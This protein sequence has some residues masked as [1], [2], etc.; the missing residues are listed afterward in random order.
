MST[1]KYYGRRRRSSPLLPD[2]VDIIIES[3]PFEACSIMDKFLVYASSIIVVGS[4]I[5]FYG[6]IITAFK[7]WRHYR[8]LANEAYAKTASNNNRY[9]TSSGESSQERS[10]KQ[11]PL[12]QEEIQQS[13]HV[14]MRNKLIPCTRQK[15]CWY[16]DSWCYLSWVPPYSQYQCF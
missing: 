8:Q 15:Q 4:P 9:A 14:T 7:R 16:V 13:N 1:N 11:P 2:G 5:W 12:S 10:E 3:P 6:F